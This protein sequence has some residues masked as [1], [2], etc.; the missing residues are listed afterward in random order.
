VIEATNGLEAIEVL[1]TKASEIDLILL[2]LHM[3]IMGGMEM[4]KVVRADTTLHQP[5]IIVLT[6]D[7][8]KHKEALQCGAND[9]VIKPIRR[10]ELFQ[11]IQK[12]LQ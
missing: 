5:P 3:P 9:F 2:D 11:K 8:S 6:T 7:D 4:I 12:V 1:K 10:E